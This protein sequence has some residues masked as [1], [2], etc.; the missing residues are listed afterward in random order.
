MMEKNNYSKKIV[1]VN[2]HQEVLPVW[3]KK[4]FEI[5]KKLKL[6]TLDYHADTVMPFRT[7][8]SKV[9][10][11]EGNNN[12]IERMQKFQSELIKLIKSNLTLETITEWSEKLNCDE[13]IMAA[14]RFGI[15]K[16]YQVIY[17]MEE[18]FRE[19][20]GEHLKYNKLDCNGIFQPSSKC[21][22]FCPY[23]ELIKCNSRLED[24]YLKSTNLEIPD[25]EFILDIDLDYFQTKKSLFPE[26][27]L[28]FKE[29]V[30]KSS[31]ITVARSRSYFQDLKI[32]GDL[33]LESAE[34][35]LIQLIEKCLEL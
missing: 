19:V 24:F 3:A 17:C 2:H 28:I 31:I 22:E 12:I 11:N 6:I 25:S 23:T 16:D 4:Y 35:Y 1:I 15:I 34:Q 32:D 33:D 29:L 8:S 26:K 30:Q 18:D 7:Y 10:L 20:G 9:V 27:H 21:T 14:Y 13:Q 5:G